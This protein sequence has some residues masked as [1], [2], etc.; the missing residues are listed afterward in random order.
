MGKDFDIASSVSYQLPFFSCPNFMISKKY[1]QDISRFLY[2]KEFGISP[3]PG[4][5]GDQPITWINK[6]S[7][8][9]S[10]L[11]KREHNMK[12]KAQQQAEKNIGNKNG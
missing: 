8:I 6:A 11:S 12:K 9:S 4:S 10:S 7:I 1:Q 5:Y 3:F 2:C